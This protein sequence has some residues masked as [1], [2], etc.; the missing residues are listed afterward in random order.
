MSVTAA[1][2]A[3]L[4]WIETHEHDLVALLQRLV[5]VPSVVGSEGACQV[6]VA[7]IMRGCCDT[8]DV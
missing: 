3:I 6:D 4:Q 1:E 2:Q 8:V 7:E 5:A